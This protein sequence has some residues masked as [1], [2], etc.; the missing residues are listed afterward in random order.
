MRTFPIVRV[1]MPLVTLA[2]VLVLAG[3]GGEGESASGAT[4]AEPTVRDSA[5]IR[6]VE[7]V[8]AALPVWTVEP[9]P[10]LSIGA[11]EG[12]DAE[13]LYQVNGITRLADGTW[14]VSN[15]G[16]EEVRLFGPD[17][18]FL[19]SVG[20]SGE[21]PGE[22]TSLS[23]T[24]VL[25]GDSI[26]VWDTRRRTMSVFDAS[27]EVARTF[28]FDD[29]DDRSVTP[30]A[31]LAD[32]RW[33]V[34][35]T[36]TFSTGGDGQ[37]NVTRPDVVAAHAGSEGGGLSVFATFAGAERWLVQS[38]AFVSIRSYP[39]GRGSDLVAGE[40]RVFGG[41]SEV[42][43]VRVWDAAGREVARWRVAAHSEPVT[44]ADWAA[45][46]DAELD[47]MDDDPALADWRRQTIEFYE[48]AAP[49]EAAPV[50]QELLIATD[51]RLWMRQFTPPSRA[52]EG[53]QWWVLEP[54][55]EV[56]RE[57]TLPP[58]FELHW[59]D[60]TQVAGVATDDFDVEYVHVYRLTPTG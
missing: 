12:T 58:G 42:P 43:E 37:G 33:I 51:G 26:A 57:V 6:I 24:W 56:V 22:F 46:R 15:G 49:P 7:N 48:D 52:Q 29:L 59:A 34:Q 9:D 41:A 17:G 36:S 54:S 3:C 20:R 14:V 11:L 30:T 25:A 23:A 50:W 19:R 10:V 44:E 47:L 1:A 39:F 53:S 4:L 60:A 8:N 21:G 32:G 35:Q 18:E 13:T 16:T 5:G 55:G 27:G 45:E 38:D 2:A 28:G 31:H 40:D